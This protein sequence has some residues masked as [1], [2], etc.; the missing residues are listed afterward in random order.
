MS[1]N[2]G[3]AEALAAGPPDTLAT[4]RSASLTRDTIRNIIRQRSALIGLTIL[5]ALFL[6]AIFAPFIAP[7][8]P[9]TSMLDLGEPGKRGAAP[10]VHLFG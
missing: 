3:S 4:Q 2:P 9:D 6:I 1:L 7:T 10:C 5:I 8:N